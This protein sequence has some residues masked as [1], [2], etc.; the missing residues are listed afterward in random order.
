MVTFNGRAK[1]FQCKKDRSEVEDVESNWG[2]KFISSVIDEYTALVAEIEENSDKKFVEGDVDTKTLFK[3]KRTVRGLL[4]NAKTKQTAAEVE[5]IQKEHDI[6]IKLH[7]KVHLDLNAGDGWQCPVAECD[8][9]NFKKRVIC[10]KCKA[11]KPTSTVINVE[12]ENSPSPEVPV[13]N[14]MASDNTTEEKT[15]EK[16]EEKTRE[17]TEEPSKDDTADSGKEAASDD[18]EM[19]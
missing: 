13:K 17:E 10:M 12:S 1:C 16:S 4:K 11:K 2:E 14:P 9:L 5:K 3:A 15:E 8:T 18:V 6:V 19:S 7:T